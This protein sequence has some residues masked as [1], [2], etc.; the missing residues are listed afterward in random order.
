MV[1]KFDRFSRDEILGEVVCK[2]NQFEFD[3]LE[4]QITLV[5][6]IA[7]RGNKV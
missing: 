2:L 3:T 6:D 5:Q 1:L 7:P 4:K